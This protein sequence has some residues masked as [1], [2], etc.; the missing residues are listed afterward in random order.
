MHSL[1]NKEQKEGVL[2][3]NA[4]NGCNADNQKAFLHRVNIVWPSIF[5]LCAVAI[6]NH[7]NWLLLE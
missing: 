1:Y 2:S 4:E 6:P 7:R 3:V 5:S